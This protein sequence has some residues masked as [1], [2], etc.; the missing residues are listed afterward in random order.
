M[1]RFPNLWRGSLE[2]LALTNLSVR[3][4]MGDH[5][6]SGRLRLMCTSA[7][8][9][10]V[11]FM[12][13]QAHLTGP[14]ALLVSGG[15]SYK[16]VDVSADTHLISVDI[17][18]SEDE[19]LG[20]PVSDMRICY[21]EY[22]R[23]W[24]RPEAF[25]AFQD[26]YAQVSSTVRSLQTYALYP[27]VERRL[28][29]S[30]ALDYLLLTAA[31]AVEEGRLCNCQGNR[32]V[33]RAVSFIHDHYMYPITAADI[34][35][36]AGI[37]VGH[38]HR[39]FQSVMGVHVGEYLTR[40]RMEKARSLLMRTDIP[41]TEIARIVGISTQQYFCRVF[42]Q[43]TGVTPQRFRHSYNVTCD[44]AAATR[45]YS[46]ST[47]ADLRAAQI[48]GAGQATVCKGG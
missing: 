34:A 29:T 5:T 42:K 10:E 32:H 24:E 36:D 14:W 25:C 48:M 13:A 2:L 47:G 19:C 3:E 41:L 4:G 26:D 46:V 40:L 22:R 20:F 1:E 12:N 35:A 23:L 30:L 44:Y 7:G 38:L 15:V 39:L 37:H 27:P 11:Q 17:G 21:P 28:F 8:G 9:C 43:Y 16:L 18:M 33:R 6:E 31:T 45:Y